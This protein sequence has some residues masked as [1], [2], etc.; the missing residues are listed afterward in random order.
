MGRRAAKESKE[1]ELNIAATSKNYDAGVQK[2]Q[3]VKIGRPGYKVTKVKNVDEE[4]G[5]VKM[6]LM[7]QIHF[8]QIKDN[9]KPRKRLMSAFEQRREMPNSAYQYLL[10]AAEPYET[11]SF[12]I[13]SGKLNVEETD[14]L[15]DDSM[16]WE[17]W[18]SDS[19]NYSV[20][21]LYD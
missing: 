2:R 15:G 13:P 20:Q 18:D 14:E 11:I 21:L 17:F 19:K 6:G 12:R 5:T 3:F 16:G 1:N 8:P 4:N 10:I 9:D 7:F